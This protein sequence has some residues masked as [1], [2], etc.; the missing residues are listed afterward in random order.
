MKNRSMPA[1][2]LMMGQEST[3]HDWRNVLRSLEMQHIRGAALY[4][5][6]KEPPRCILLVREGTRKIPAWEKIE[7]VVNRY[8]Q[9]TTIMRQV[10]LGTTDVGD[11]ALIIITSL[12][13]H[14]IPIGQR[15]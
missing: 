9:D 12:K 8:V 3:W 1:H 10:S 15:L 7:E 2:Y 13:T 6:V 14:I 5:S 11:P 4:K